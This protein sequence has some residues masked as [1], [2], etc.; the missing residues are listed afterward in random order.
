MQLTIPHAVVL[1]SRPV[2]QAEPAP[3]IN[4]QT[5]AS[6]F[7][8]D[9]QRKIVKLEG[10]L[11][12]RLLKILDFKGED[13]IHK[14][15]RFAAASSE[16]PGL[17]RRAAFAG[18]LTPAIW[19][20]LAQDIDYRTRFAVLHDPR[21]VKVLSNW[22]LAA[23][24]KGDIT[25]AQMLLKSLAANGCEPQHMEKLMTEVDLSGNKIF[26]LQ[27]KRL[28]SKS[29]WGS[30]SFTLDDDVERDLALEAAFAQ[31]SN[32][33]TAGKDTRPFKTK[34]DTSNQTNETKERL[35]SPI[36]FGLIDRMAFL[37]SFFQNGEL[38]EF[39]RKL[40]L[41]AAVLPL[42]C[43]EIAALIRVLPKD[44]HFDPILNS[45]AEL[46]DPEINIALSERP[47]LPRLALKYLR[48]DWSY[49]VRRNRLANPQMLK[50]VEPIDI[51]RQLDQDPTLID[52][53]V[54]FEI[55]AVVSA[56]PH[57]VSRSFF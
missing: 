51:K 2:P 27:L 33:L 14:H 29:P 8:G 19:A 42:T 9:I 49:A 11:G 38:T 20:S 10:D 47:R 52:D 39:L 1:I 45:A 54:E 48:D 55:E 46:Q 26:R 53:A 25:A 37:T 21:A 35:L 16:N 41:D 43:S 17:R 34:G 24:V 4:A 57:L 32:A 13:A 22:S 30:S 18:S 15:F 12:L 44:T 40:L 36:A 50:N 5:L 31:A 7:F 3:E 28:L 6:E 56:A 23:A